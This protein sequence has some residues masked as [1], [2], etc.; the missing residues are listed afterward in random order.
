MP[1]FLI[2]EMLLDGYYYTIVLSGIQY[3]FSIY[4]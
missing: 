1:V 4:F 2:K 3:L